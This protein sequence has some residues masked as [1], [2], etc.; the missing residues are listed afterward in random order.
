MEENRVFKVKYVII[1]Y[2]LIGAFFAF[3]SQPL[4]NKFG[5]LGVPI[6]HLVSIFLPVI[7]LTG[8]FKKSYKDVF[9]LNKP[10]NSRYIFIGIG[11]WFLAMIINLLYAFYI[12]KFLPPEQELIETFEYLYNNTVLWQ[13]LLMMALMPA[14]TE[15]L[16][17]RGF[18]FSSLLNKI[19][20][21]K[22]IIISSAMFAILHFSLMKFFTTFL[23]GIVFGYTVY[24]TKSVYSSMILHFLNNGI[25]S[26]AQYFAANYQVE[27]SI[28]TIGNISIFTCLALA[29]ILISLKNRRMELLNFK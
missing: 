6:C 7:I 18:V 11:L 3:V 2:V 13:Q 19:S 29:Y 28:I 25:A 4:F 12:M 23:L 21:T 20:P 17:F 16:L 24:K 9:L 15:E 1:I 8:I 14:I 10:E 27:P 5:I 26:I 22:A